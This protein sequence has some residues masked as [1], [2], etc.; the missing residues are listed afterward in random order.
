MYPHYGLL[1]LSFGL[2]SESLCSSSFWSWVLVLELKADD[3]IV[4]AS[5]KSRASATSRADWI[6]A[7]KSCADWEADIFPEDGG[8]REQI[9][10]PPC[11]RCRCTAFAKR[12]AAKGLGPDAK[13]RNCVCSCIVMIGEKRNQ[14]SKKWFLFLSCRLKKEAKGQAKFSSKPLRIPQQQSSRVEGQLVAT[15]T[16]DEAK[17]DAKKTNASETPTDSSL[18]FC[19]IGKT[20][21]RLMAS[22]LGGTKRDVVAVKMRTY[23]WAGWQAEK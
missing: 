1:L 17:K 3:D 12:M 16:L 19:Q 4:A 11:T 21:T 10:L 13:L 6:N 20:K 22:R 8:S 9:V 7:C 5:G 2:G 15:M 23:I 18:R 14:P